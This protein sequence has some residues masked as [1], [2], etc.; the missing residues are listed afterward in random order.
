MN[1]GVITGLP[2]FKRG[3]V[4][5]IYDLGDRLLIVATD[6]ISCFDVVLPTGIPGKGKILLEHYSTLSID[7]DFVQRQCRQG[8]W[9]GE[10]RLMLALLQDAINCYYACLWARDKK[11]K[12][13]FRET[14]QWI[15]E[16][17]SDCIYSFETSVRDLG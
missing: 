14:E 11:G 16:R 5:D 12:E 8:V 2:L 7:E 3:K 17:N 15:M 13:L 1:K 9:G 10:H 6:S 4:R